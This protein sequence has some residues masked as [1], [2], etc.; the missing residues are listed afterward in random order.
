M[1]SDGQCDYS[2][3]TESETS[4]C[5]SAASRAT[6]HSLLST[7]DL[8]WE[9]ALMGQT[10]QTQLPRGATQFVGNSQ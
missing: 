7:G 3:E 5:S 6:H 9:R 4:S 10:A 8:I 2:S 1:R